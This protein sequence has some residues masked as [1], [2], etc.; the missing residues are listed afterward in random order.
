MSGLVVARSLLLGADHTARAYA[1]V[2]LHTRVRVHVA[3][4]GAVRVTSAGICVRPE[5]G[6]R[7]VMMA[8]VAQCRSLGA[9]AGRGLLLLVSI[10]VVVAADDAAS[11]DAGA[12]PTSRCL[13]PPADVPRG[14]GA[15]VS[16]VHVLACSYVAK[17][18]FRAVQ[19]MINECR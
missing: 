6:C 7:A 15:V 14:R 3:G 2:S 17:V 10:I 18:K 19:I 8:Q 1:R 9:A 5:P 4:A 13:I 11:N 16:W 12:L